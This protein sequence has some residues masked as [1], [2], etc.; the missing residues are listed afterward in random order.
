MFT[1]QSACI[2]SSEFD[3]PETDGF[4]A[5]CDTPLSEKIFNIA[6]TEIEAIVE[7]NGVTDDIGWESVAFVCIHLLILA[8]SDSQLGDTL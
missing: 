1:F 7:P 8:N 5:H 3:T 4:S 6:M 2:N